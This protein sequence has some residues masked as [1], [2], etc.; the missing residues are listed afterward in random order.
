MIELMSICMKV[1]DPDA[2]HERVGCTYK[3]HYA[4]GDFMIHVSGS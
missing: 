2:A 3:E 4:F 1:S